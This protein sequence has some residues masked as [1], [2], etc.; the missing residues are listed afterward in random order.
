M[1]EENTLGAKPSDVDTAGADGGLDN[2]LSSRDH[3]VA[4]ASKALEAGLQ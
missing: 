2:P 1:K 3:G 4:G